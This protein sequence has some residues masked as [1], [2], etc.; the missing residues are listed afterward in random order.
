MASAR[1][2]ELAGLNCGCTKMIFAFAYARECLR[3]RVWKNMFR[4]MLFIFF[5]AIIPVVLQAV[6]LIVAKDTVI[7][8]GVAVVMVILQM[9][10]ISYY[11]VHT[12]LEFFENE[13]ESG[14]EK[15]IRDMMEK[16]IMRHEDEK[17]KTEENGKNNN[18][19]ESQE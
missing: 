10:A 3:G 5:A 6:A 4:I 2:F 9:V 19:D 13:K 12:A 18:E 7:F 15:R 8:I 17:N 11:W 16:A 1:A 14:I